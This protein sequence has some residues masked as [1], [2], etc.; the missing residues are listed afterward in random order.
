M[1]TDNRYM[2][3]AWYWDAAASMWLCVRHPDDREEARRIAAIPTDINVP[4][5]EWATSAEDAQ[6]K[7]R[8]RNE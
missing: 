3:G 6:E 1:M 4:F 5:V 2:L 7:W 8:M